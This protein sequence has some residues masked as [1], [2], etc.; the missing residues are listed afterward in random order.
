[1]VNW[2]V[3]TLFRGYLVCW[4]VISWFTGLLG[5]Y[6]VV[7]WFVGMLFRC[8]VVCW[9]IISWLTDLLGCYFL[10]I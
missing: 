8:Y 5:R 1:M 6:F 10:V 4:D 7:N 2:F 9:D 3:G